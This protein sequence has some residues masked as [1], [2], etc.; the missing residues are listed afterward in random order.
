MRKLAAL[1][2][3]V[4]LVM[5]MCMPSA[6]AADYPIPIESRYCDS[7][8]RDASIWYSDELF[9]T[10]LP[11]LMAADV[12]TGGYTELGDHMVDAMRR[13]E[14]YIGATDGMLC[15]WFVTG[16]GTTVVYYMPDVGMLYVVHTGLIY[17]VP[18]MAQIEGFDYKNIPNEDMLELF[19]LIFNTK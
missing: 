12:G 13:G 15:G 2:L 10:M 16:D 4:M 6:L 19:P 14:V 9:R 17:N 1:A 3:S 8:C 5:T 11:L 18:V 7:I